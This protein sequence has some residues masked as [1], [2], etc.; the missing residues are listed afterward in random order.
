MGAY[1]RWPGHPNRRYLAGL[2]TCRPL[3]LRLLGRCMDLE[4]RARDELFANGDVGPPDE[5]LTGQ[6]RDICRAGS[7]ESALVPSGGVLHDSDPW[8]F[9]P[10]GAV[11]SRSGAESGRRQQFHELRRIRNALAH[12]SA[13][14]WK[15]ASV[16]DHLE[17]AFP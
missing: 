14:G 2:V 12:G 17:S 10:F 5:D 1:R 4:Q 11:L 8:D 9:A 6:A 16:V 7:V 13:V 3:A 15:A